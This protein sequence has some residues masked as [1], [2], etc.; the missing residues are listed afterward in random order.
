[1]PDLRDGQCGKMPRYSLGGGGLAQLE[2]TDALR[3]EELQDRKIRPGCSKA[4]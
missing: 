1:M 4:D 2:F 3:L